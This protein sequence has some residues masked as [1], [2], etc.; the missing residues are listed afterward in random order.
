ME[1][2][3]HGAPHLLIRGLAH[4]RHAPRRELRRQ[5]DRECRGV[6]QHAIQVPGIDLIVLEREDPDPDWEEER[7][8]ITQL[9]D[10]RPYPTSRLYTCIDGDYKPS[11]SCVKKICSFPRPTVCIGVT[12]EV[13]CTYG[14]G[15]GRIWPPRC[16]VIVAVLGGRCHPLPV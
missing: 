16:A 1:R 7:A 13:A 11:S 6:Q 12:Y 5:G 8:G 10:V 15:D 3:Q 4:T 2:P 14:C 9:T